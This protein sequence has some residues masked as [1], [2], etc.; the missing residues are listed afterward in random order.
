[1]NKK[2]VH[3]VLNNKVPSINNKLKCISSGG[4]GLFAL[5]MYNAL[6]R[7]GVSCS[8]VL[9]DHY[10]TQ[11]EVNT[12]IESTGKAG[13]NSAY[14]HLI[15]NNLKYGEGLPDMCNGHLCVQFEGQLYDNEGVYKGIPISRH[16]TPKTMEVFIEVDDCWN[17]TFKCYNKG[18]RDIKETI[19][20]FFENIFNTHLT[21]STT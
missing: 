14:Q 16:I 13:I 12:L 3:S 19:K 9:V 1:M 8:I 15:S 21:T 10:Y 5:E 11:E 18:V 6:K 4:C 2:Q 7:K 20:R 17:S